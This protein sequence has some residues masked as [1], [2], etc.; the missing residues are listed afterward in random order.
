MSTKFIIPKSIANGLFLRAGELHVLEVIGKC[1]SLLRRVPRRVWSVDRRVIVSLRWKVSLRYSL[2]C[3]C[4]SNLAPGVAILSY[5]LL[6]ELI[7]NK[8]S[9]RRLWNWRL[10]PTWLR[11]ITIR[12]VNVLIRLNHFEEMSLL[13][14]I[15]RENPLK[16]HTCTT[17]SIGA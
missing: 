14:N 9:R 3:G 1:S 8:E 15:C 16:F 13:V 5:R 2:C 10:I 17:S 7:L 4:T 12:K 6:R 11:I